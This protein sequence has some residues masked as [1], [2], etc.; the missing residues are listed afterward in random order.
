MSD[1]VEYRMTGHPCQDA[2]CNPANRNPYSFCDGLSPSVDGNG[3]ITY[4][5]TDDD[6]LNDC[7]EFLLKS[8]RTNFDS[9]G[10]FIPDFL[11]FKANIPFIAGTTSA[12][13]MPMGDGMTNYA[14]MKGG[15]PLAVP[16]TTLLNFQPRVTSS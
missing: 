2:N 12:T 3:N 11:Q 7:E 15:Y 10:D 6:G 8:D 13:A 1:L 4:P 5:D 14:K 9:N 16:Y